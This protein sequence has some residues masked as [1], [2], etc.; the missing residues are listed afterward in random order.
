[1]TQLK[2]IL[3]PT[4]RIRGNNGINVIWAEGEDP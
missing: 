2:A 1:M 3:L 4:I